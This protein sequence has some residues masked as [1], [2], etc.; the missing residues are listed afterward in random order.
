MNDQTQEFTLL[1]FSKSPTDVVQDKDED[2]QSISS[3]GVS[4]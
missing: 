1:L 3:I 4:K 2:I